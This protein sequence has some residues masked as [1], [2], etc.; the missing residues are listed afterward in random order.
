MTKK[1]LVC[2]G[3]DSSIFSKLLNNQEFSVY[4]EAKNPQEIVR[5]EARDADALVIRSSTKVTKDFIDSCSNLKLVIRAGEGTDNIDKAYC[6]EKGIKVANTPGANNNSAAEHAIALMFTLLRKTAWANSSMQTGKW[7]KAR[8]TGNEMT[9]K[10]IGVIGFGRI[11]QLVAKRLIGFDPEILFYDPFISSHSIGYDNIKK[12][13]DLETIFK[14]SDI[15]TVHVPL[16][17]QTK[18]LIDKKHFSL[19]KNNAIFVNA[20]RGGIVHEGDLLDALKNKS[21]RAAALDVFL[22]EPLKEKTDLHEIENLI[23]TPHLGG[24][25]QEAQYRVGEM[26]YHQLKEFFMNDN[27]LNEVRA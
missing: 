24:S 4:P 17:N 8:F 19:M 25:T 20:A 22:N 15:I 16:V 26:A 13:D 27:L 6:K 14:K 9:N 3:M 11:G 18:N 21:I 10:T 12:V 5:K 7:D 1:I 23:L 2:D